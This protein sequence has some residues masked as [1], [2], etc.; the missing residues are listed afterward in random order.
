MLPAGGEPTVAD[1][2][3]IG[4]PVSPSCRAQGFVKGA[5]WAHW[6]DF[7]QTVVPNNRCFFYVLNSAAQCIFP[8]VACERRKDCK[9]CVCPV[10]APA[11]YMER[12]A[13]MR[14][15]IAEVPDIIAT[16]PL[17]CKCLIVRVIQVVYRH[18]EAAL[19]WCKILIFIKCEKSYRNMKKK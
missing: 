2:A 17:L 4:P 12:T 8:S 15:S 13:S 19:F 6:G 11:C 7:P 9:V 5:I 10:C 18:V 1:C 3:R 14:M 16:L